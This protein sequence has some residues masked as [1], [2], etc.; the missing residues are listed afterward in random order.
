MLLAKGGTGDAVATVFTE[1]S[2]RLS[3]SCIDI[4]TVIK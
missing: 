4:M 3:I 1:Y 2:T